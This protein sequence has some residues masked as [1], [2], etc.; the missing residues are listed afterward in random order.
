VLIDF[1]MGSRRCGLVP[2]VA[3]GTLHDTGAA[4]L[5][6]ISGARAHI[7]CGAVR[8]S[9]PPRCIHR[10][11]H[12]YSGGTPEASEMSASKHSQALM[13]AGNGG[14]HRVAASREQQDSAETGNDEC[15]STLCTW[16]V[17]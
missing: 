7:A 12:G 13:G 6:V 14:K 3:V 10:A 11:T 17:P 15:T 2:A 8:E 4:S 5:G 1:L 16:N 9:L